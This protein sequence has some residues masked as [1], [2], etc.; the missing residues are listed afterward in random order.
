MSAG[1]LSTR[2]YSTRDYNNK[3]KVKG[4]VVFDGNGDYLS[5]NS[6]SAFGFGTSDYTVEAFI[7]PGTA[8]SSQIIC[9]GS[10][11]GFAF[12]LGNGFGSSL[13]GLQVT[14][15]LTADFDTCNF[16]FN[17][18]TWYHVAVVRSSGTVT[19]YVNGTSRTNNSTANS[20][21]N[22][23][24][25]TS[26][27]VGAAING[28]ETYNGYIS[29]VRVVKSAVYTGNFTTPTMPLDPI[30]NTTLLTA[31]DPTTLRDSSSN[32]WTVTA[33]GNAAASTLSPF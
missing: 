7:R 12:R 22:W 6:T 28:G 20:G 1:L 31:A 10:S 18:N 30:T 5:I 9:G 3:F 29:N 13:N 23:G 19:F 32:A 33:N 15:S 26:S 27:T 8:S 11:G 4:S 24:N 21:F 14:R 2:L 25:E 16:T 17:T